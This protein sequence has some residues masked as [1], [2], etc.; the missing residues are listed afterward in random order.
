MSKQDKDVQADVDTPTHVPAT[1]KTDEP[2]AEPVAIRPLAGSTPFGASHQG[3]AELKLANAELYR[4]AEARLKARDAQLKASDKLIQS[5]G[6]K[7]KPSRSDVEAAGWVIDHESEPEMQSASNQKGETVNLEVRQGH[8][9]AY[10][11]I[12]GS[13]FELEAHTP[14]LLHERIAAYEADTRRDGAGV[15]AEPPAEV[16]ELLNSPYA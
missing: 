16:K 4:N 15:I 8:Y 12:G 7:S 9:R 1:E 10:K 3:T 6:S 2:L 5:R 14:E 13:L 11:R